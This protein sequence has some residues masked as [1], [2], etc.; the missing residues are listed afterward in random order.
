MLELR[1]YPAKFE[2]P[3]IDP[4]AVVHCPKASLTLT[5]AAKSCPGCEHYRGCVRAQDNPNESWHHVWR[6]VC[7]YPMA[8]RCDI[9]ASGPTEF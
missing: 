9:M 3:K 7:Q 5:Y 6:I 1:S 8:R 2:D 4:R